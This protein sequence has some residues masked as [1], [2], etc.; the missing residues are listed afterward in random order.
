MRKN[1]ID[2]EVIP[3]DLDPKS[4][5]LGKKDQIDLD[6]EVSDGEKKVLMQNLVPFLNDV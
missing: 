6:Y 5:F 3:Y 4:V 2:K 1:L